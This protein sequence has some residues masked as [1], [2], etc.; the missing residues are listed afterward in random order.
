MNCQSSKLTEPLP[1]RGEPLELGGFYSN[2][3][4]NRTPEQQ[5]QLER[6][7]FWE[8]HRRQQ[9]QEEAQK[10]AKP[11]QRSSWPQYLRRRQ[12]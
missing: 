7:I 5:I 3:S 11:G 9:E 10:Q 12:S 2:D 8:N 1:K 4:E 6:D